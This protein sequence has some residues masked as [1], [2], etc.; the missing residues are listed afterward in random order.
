VKPDTDDVITLPKFDVLL[1]AGVVLK[2]ELV[3]LDKYWTRADHGSR[4]SAGYVV[5][6]LLAVLGRCRVYSIDVESKISS[7]D[8]HEISVSSI[9]SLKNRQA[10]LERV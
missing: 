8:T 4:T 7:R 3:G 1:F 2:R 10:E 5:H 9:S 6:S